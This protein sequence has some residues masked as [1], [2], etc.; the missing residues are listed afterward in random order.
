[1][2]DCLNLGTPEKMV[3]TVFEVSCRWWPVANT[4]FYDVTACVC[5]V[6]LLKAVLCCSRV[7]SAVSRISCTHTSD[8]VSLHCNSATTAYIMF[9]C[10]WQWPRLFILMMLPEA[11][12]ARDGMDFHTHGDQMQPPIRCISTQRSLSLPWQL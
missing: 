12:T 8:L 1:M 6:G 2:C 3:A 10:N 9:D 4:A 5:I 11:S 7:G